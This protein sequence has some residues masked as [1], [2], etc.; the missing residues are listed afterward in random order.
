MSDERWE[1]EKI[2]PPEAVTIARPGF[3]GVEAYP[4]AAGYGDGYDYAYPEND[5]RLYLRRM[6]RAIKKRKLVMIVIAVIVTAVVTLEVFRTKSVYQASTTIEIQKENRTLVQSGDLIV[7]TDESDD[8]YYVAMGMKTKIRLLQSRPLLEDVVVNL[9][10]D[11]NPNFMDITTRK[12]YVEAIKTVAS[13]FRGKPETPATVAVAETPVSAFA[14]DVVRSRQESA[15][16]A[17]YVDVLAA[18]LSAEPLPDTRML[19]VSFTHTDPALAATVVDNIAQVFIQRSFVNRTEKYSNTSEWLDKSTRE[20]KAR[21]EEAEQNLVNYSK[22][23]NIYS[24]EGKENL[25]TDKLTRLHDQAT[26]AQTDRMLKESLYQEVKAGRVAQLPEAFSDPKT[27]DLQKKL[28]ELTTEVSQLD[29]TY[30]PKNFRVIEKRQQIAAIQQQISESRSSLEEKLRADYERAVR[31]EASLQAALNLAKTEAA[32]QNQDAIQFNILKQEVETTKALYKDFLQKTNQAKIQEHEQHGNMKM[33][34]PP[35]V[36]TAPVGPNR[37][38]TIFI[39]LL[40]SLMAGVGLAFF[41]EYLDNTVKTVE[42]VSRYAQLPALSVIPAISGRRK[43]ALLVS[44]NNGNKKPAAQLGLGNGAQSSEKLM[45]LDSRS[46][47]AEAYRV[48]RTSVLLSSVDRPPKTILITSGQPGEGK[49]TTV[50]N[51]AISLAQLGAKVLIIDCDLRKPAVHKVLGL[52]NHRGFTTLFSSGIPIDRVIQKLSIENLSVLPSGP[53]PP[54]PS[55]MI[56]SAKM[57][58][59]LQ[60]LADTYD[61]I[62]IDSPP[63]LRVTDPVI[64]STMVDG[65]ILVVHGGKSTREVVRRTRQELSVAGARIFGV[66]LNN[67]DTNDGGYEDYYYESYS[68]YEEQ[69]A[70][71]SGA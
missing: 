34:D 6:W 39:G 7:Q 36:P 27:N 70:K 61:H 22:A 23:H 42:D 43:S 71:A 30:G 66:V 16:L 59:T 33:I 69:S 45:L 13:K 2:S 10:L 54:N 58:R 5:E 15:R 40:V 12:S 62:I 11:Q 56:S 57:K 18:N 48:L 63:L 46:S 21:V 20:F 47:V 68:D 29:V 4:D 35:Q 60:A 55:E 14:G 51:T 50:V 24:I 3:S 37:M 26:R 8:T 31:D 32:Q 41:L 65:V 9:K 64:L 17:P 25:A 49:T 44:S 67:V 19:V 28:G 53:I 1:L 52:G 38:R